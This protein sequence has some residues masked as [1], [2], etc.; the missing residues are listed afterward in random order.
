MIWILL[1]IFLA[2]ASLAGTLYLM[3]R[4]KR[5]GFA[6]KIS[7]KNK[8][9]GWIVSAWPLV[10]CLPFL[11]VNIYAFVIAYVNLIIIWG[12]CDLVGYIIRRVRKKERRSRYITGYI[13]LGL[14][15]CYLIW[16]WI[17]AH[18]VLRTEYRFETAK[19]LGQEDLRIAVIGD[20]HLGI[21]LD[22]G[23]FEEQCRRIADEK[24]DVVMAV[25]D[26]VDDDSTKK[27]MLAACESLASIPAKYGIYWIYGN[28]DRGYFTYRDF[29]ADELYDKLTSCGIKVLCDQSD[30]MNGF[31]TVVGREDRSNA[32]R[33]SAGDVMKNAD[34][35]RY[36]IMLDHQ[37][38]DYAAEAETHP[39]LVLSG[40][41]HGGHIF[42]AGLVGALIGANDRIYGTETR[43]D[44]TFVVTSGISGW[45]IPFKP[46]AI[47]E[48]V[49]IDVHSTA[50]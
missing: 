35:S 6:K 12:A 23:E 32:D 4:A 24:P 11:I 21:T 27:D 40:H 28:H 8:V 9:L 39:D 22:S 41:T 29:S 45:G 30:D 36:V 42:P 47:S 19:A 44:T 17:M 37:P 10:I 2:G 33:L 46:F 38:N 5:F 49:I 26:F 3:N 48:Y 15:A 1:L 16:G 18:T 14:T 34:T 43:D 20:L 50:G 7:E 31:V 25:G 13:A